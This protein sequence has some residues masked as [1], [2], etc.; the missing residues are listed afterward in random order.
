MLLV[1]KLD[2]RAMLPTVAHPGEDLGYD[3]YAL[4]DCW[5]VKGR[6][7]VVRTGIACIA[8]TSDAAPLGLLIKER[9]SMALRGVFAN[10]GVVDAGYRGE[11]MV[12]LSTETMTPY[13]VMA[14][15]KI[16]QMIPLPILTGA[17][18]EVAGLSESARGSGGF[19]STGK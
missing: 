2:E 15:D 16:A 14:G 11:I 18:I 10:A 5:V 9:S 8:Y 12:L 1:K 7:A 13:N 3:L 4:E 6:I 17:V 19:G